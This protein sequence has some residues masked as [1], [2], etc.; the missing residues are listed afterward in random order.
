M[1]DKTKID[2]C[3]ACDDCEKHEDVCWND[4]IFKRYDCHETIKMLLA[5]AREA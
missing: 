1:G 2:W 3:D 4:C 5:M